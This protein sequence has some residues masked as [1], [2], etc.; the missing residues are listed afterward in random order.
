MLSLVAYGR[1]EVKDV[2]TYIRM[3]IRS[4]SLC[5]FSMS[6]Q[7][8]WLLRCRTLYVGL[9]RQYLSQHQNMWWVSRW[10]RTCT[11]ILSIF[12]ACSSLDRINPVK[13][14]TA[15]TKFEGCVVTKWEGS[16]NRSS[17]SRAAAAAAAADQQE[18]QPNS[19][20]TSLPIVQPH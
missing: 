11:S 16:V 18:K 13:L 2:S 4:G 14:C 5:H 7:A 6:H 1:R 17:C 15:Q 9:H 12:V 19:P 3:L 20:R 8:S 10:M